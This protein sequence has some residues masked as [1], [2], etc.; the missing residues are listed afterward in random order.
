MQNEKSDNL[1]YEK[2]LTKGV[3]LRQHSTLNCAHFF[4]LTHIEFL[5]N[6]DVLLSGADAIELVLMHVHVGICRQV[7][8][9][10]CTI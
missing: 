1:K 7:C 2:D 8:N 10:Y 3:Q 6:V 5:S 4:V 9:I